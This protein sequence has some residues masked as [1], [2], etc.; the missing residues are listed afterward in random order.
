MQSHMVRLLVEHDGRLRHE[1]GFELLREQREALVDM[2]EFL[3]LASDAG[4]LG[5]NRAQQ[6]LGD[7]SAVTGRTCGDQRRSPGQRQIHLAER[8]THT[9]S[10]GGSSS[11]SR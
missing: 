10:L 6:G 4:A 3:D 11:Y 2:A 7:Q 5:G 1:P 8:D 9:Q